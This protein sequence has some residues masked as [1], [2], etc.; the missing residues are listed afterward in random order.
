M[1][2]WRHGLAPPPFTSA[3]VLVLCVP[4]RAAASC[5]VTTWC[6]TATF[7]SAPKIASGSSTEPASLPAGFF[8][9]RVL[10]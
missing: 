9:F 10:T 6:I 5:A 2:F 3:R 1:P 4:A 7:G 8:V